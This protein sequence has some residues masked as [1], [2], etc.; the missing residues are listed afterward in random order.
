MKTKVSN[1]VQVGLELIANAYHTISYFTFL[2]CIF[3]HVKMLHHNNNNNKL[4]T[5]A[6]I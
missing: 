1:S 5:R 3:K 6:G 2:F 4:S